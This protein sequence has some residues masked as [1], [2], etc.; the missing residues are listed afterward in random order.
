MQHFKTILAIARSRWIRK[1]ICFVSLIGLPSVLYAGQYFQNFPD[2]S[3]GTTNFNDGSTLSSTALGTVA[4]L[5][6]LAESIGIGSSYGEL[7]LTESGMTNVQSAFELP[8]L[9]SGAPIYAF[10]AKW[11]SDVYGTFPAFGKGFSFNFGPF[12]SVNLITNNAE[13]TGYGAGLCFSVQTDAGTNSGFYLLANG[14][15]IA[16]LTNNPSVEWG[17]NSTTRHFWEVD[18]NYY[19]GMSVRLDGQPIFTN[20]ATTG[21]VPEGGDVFAWGARCDTNTEELRLDNI[22][23]V[24]GGNLV[25]LPP[26]GPY[27][28]EGGLGGV[29]GHSVT[30]AFD[31]ANSTYYESEGPSTVGATFSP[32]N[33]VL[34]YALTSGETA[35]GTPHA[36]SLEGSTNSGESLTEIGIGAGYFVN[37]AETRVW[38][39]TN[40]IPCDAYEL[41]YS[42]G[43]GAVNTIGELRL[44]ALS[45]V[46]PPYAAWVKTGAP[47]EDWTSIAS[48]SDGTRLAAAGGIVMLSTNSGATWTRAN[49]ASTAIVV[50]SSDGTKFAAAGPSGG[51]QIETNVGDIFYLDYS[52]PDETWES[53]ACSSNGAVLAG[54]VSGG[55]IYISADSGITWAATAS[56]QTWRRVTVSADGSTLAAVVYGGGIYV[57]TNLGSLWTATSAPTNDWIGIAASSDGTKLAAASTEGIYVSANSGSTWSLIGAPH[58]E[59]EAIASSWDGSRLAAGSSDPPGVYLSMDSGN[60]WINSGAPEADFVSIASSSDG[61]KLAAC[62]DGSIYTYGFSAP[63]ST[64]LTAKLS[65][66]Y[67]V[68]SWSTTNAGNFVLQES[69]NLTSTNWLNVPWPVTTNGSSYQVTDLPATGQKFYRLI[70]Q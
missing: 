19:S 40:S 10:S 26:S 12:S 42:A 68:L 44:Y 23:A 54:A 66:G 43:F 32:P 5:T 17:T 3:N 49:A 28:A 27:F 31:G 16:S 18:W 7:Q 51:S 67:P 50:S 8:D 34:V 15:V 64:S 52:S 2:F 39:V 41:F 1:V 29:D 21:F 58:I 59:W 35:A 55:E 47:D 69:T 56:T 33:T 65:G 36:W 45:L 25:Q 57:S 62:D 60:T 14:A 61:T 22:V 11:N 6:N 46:A 48:S 53:L 37:G 30:N 63:P 9:D 20:V 13:E 38:L 24:T 70:A 4:C